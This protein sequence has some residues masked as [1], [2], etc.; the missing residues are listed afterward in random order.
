MK[1]CIM[2][3]LA[4][5]GDFGTKEELKVIMTMLFKDFE[6]EHQ[7]L[8]DTFN[9]DPGEHILSLTQMKIVV[10]SVRGKYQLLFARCEKLCKA[11]VK[12]FDFFAG[13]N[14]NIFASD[15]NIKVSVTTSG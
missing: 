15:F 11:H 13:F 4:W 3:T 14:H 12:G 2:M 9:V 1:Y 7:G 10:G 5:V 6:S 8:S